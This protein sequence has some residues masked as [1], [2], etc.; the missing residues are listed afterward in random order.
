MNYHTYL[1]SGESPITTIEFLERLNFYSQQKIKESDPALRTFKRKAYRRIY[2]SIRA[3]FL[4]SDIITY[5]DIITKIEMTDRMA[6]HIAEVFSLKW[7]KE[8]PTKE[9]IIAMLTEV[10][11]I[12]ESLADKLY[13]SGIRGIDGLMKKGVFESL[14]LESRLFLTHTPLRK[15]PRELIT[16][17]EQTFKIKNIIPGK[18]HIVGSYRRRMPFSRDID[19]LVVYNGKEP[20][21]FLDG[22]I[23]RVS[24][25]PLF[26]FYVYAQGPDKVSGILV[27]KNGLYN[28]KLDFFLT[29]RSEYPYALLYSTGSK[30]HNLMMRRA[31]KNKGLLLN[32]RGLYKKGTKQLVKEYIK[33]EA[34]VFTL[35]GLKYTQPWDRI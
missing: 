10:S 7:K 28:V 21:E 31:A 12:G 33:T 15:I 23:Q 3:S 13:R 4:L 24:A 19:I 2:D 16:T 17:I 9:S 1:G 14:P 26:K 5:D 29:N 11:G 22:I 35:L 27:I 32:Q 18:W 20:K 6:N 25:V 34:E 30:E 8:L